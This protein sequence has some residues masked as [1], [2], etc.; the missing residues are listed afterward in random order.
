MLASYLYLRESRT[1][2]SKVS[3]RI[4]SS[5]MAIR[6]LQHHHLASVHYSTWPSAYSLH[7]T[8][9]VLIKFL[10][11]VTWR[12]EQKF[13]VLPEGVVVVVHACTFVHGCGMIQPGAGGRKAVIDHGTARVV[14]I[15]AAAI[16]NA[17]KEE[18]GTKLGV[19]VPQRR[20]RFVISTSYT[21]VVPLA[22]VAF[23]RWRRSWSGG[24]RLW[25]GVAV[26]CYSR[27]G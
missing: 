10:A 21:V 16:F 27:H 3:L 11:T 6:S 1:V 2:G 7:E 4:A 19:R 20:V 9:L 18:N 13:R 25:L 8:Q 24:G 14:A 5:F 15:L 12:T 26:R 22:Q 17:I 23:V